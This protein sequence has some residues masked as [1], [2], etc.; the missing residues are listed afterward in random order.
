MERIVKGGSAHYMLFTHN[1]ITDSP[2]SGSCRSAAPGRLRICSMDLRPS[3]T[4]FVRP[5]GNCPVSTDHTHGRTR[6][7][8]SSVKKTKSSSLG[9]PNH[10]RANWDTSLLSYRGKLD[11]NLPSQFASDEFVLYN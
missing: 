11:I 10:W 3:S 2:I 8:T 9:L 6:T 1:S 7:K 5:L 4:T